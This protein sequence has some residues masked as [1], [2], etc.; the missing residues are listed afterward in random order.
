MDSPWTELPLFE[1]ALT[2]KGLLPK[3]FERTLLSKISKIFENEREVVDRSVEISVERVRKIVCIRENESK[4]GLDQRYKVA[5]SKLTDDKILPN[6]ETPPKK[7]IKNTGG[8][9]GDDRYG[10]KLANDYHKNQSKLFSYDNLLGREFHKL[11]PAIKLNK[12]GYFIHNDDTPFSTEDACRVIDK[13]TCMFL[14]Y[15]IRLKNNGQVP[16]GEWEPQNLSDIQSLCELIL[17]GRVSLDWGIENDL[18]E[19]DAYNNW[20][21][22]VMIIMSYAALVVVLDMIVKKQKPRKKKPVVKRQLLGCCAMR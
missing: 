14:Q 6:K 4:P 11:T 7:L 21:S 17:G 8:R 5:L 22:H 20:K 12:K 15:L 10:K 1:A 9:Q 18:L 19:K 3:E 16:S 13:F 2:K